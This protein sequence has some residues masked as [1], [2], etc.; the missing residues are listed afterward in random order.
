MTSFK[1]EGEVWGQ[2]FKTQRKKNHWALAEHPFCCALSEDQ[3]PHTMPQRLEVLENVPLKGP[4]LASPEGHC[5]GLVTNCCATQLQAPGRVPK[6][7]LD[8]H[9]VCRLEDERP[10]GPEAGD[11]SCPA[12]S[13]PSLCTAP[14]L[15]SSEGQLPRPY[16]PI[17]G[18]R[19][20]PWRLRR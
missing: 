10:S 2:M 12:M 7:Q 4:P 11:T 8:L 3:D 17:P 15:P 9:A 16:F 20:L 1:F 13:G 6:S 18:E 5:Q 19:G 14:P